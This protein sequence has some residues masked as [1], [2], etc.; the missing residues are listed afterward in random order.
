MEAAQGK[1]EDR[2]TFR[3]TVLTIEL[4]HLTEVL[5]RAYVIAGNRLALSAGWGVSGAGVGCL[6]I[7][8]IT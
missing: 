8:L 3:N 5:K 2:K 4:A 7:I 1:P 6:G